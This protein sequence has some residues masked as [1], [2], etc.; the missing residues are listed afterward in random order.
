MWS[1]NL[2][3]RSVILSLASSQFAS[4]DHRFNCLGGDKIDGRDIVQFVRPKIESQKCSLCS[5]QRIV[6][7]LGTLAGGSIPS[8]SLSLS[9]SLSLRSPC[10]TPADPATSHRTPAPRGCHRR[11]HLRATCAPIH[12]RPCAFGRGG[13]IATPLWLPGEPEE[14]GLD[15]ACEPAT[16]HRRHR[17]HAAIGTRRV[18]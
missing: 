18:H 6:G 3:E 15:C 14:G 1:G 9:P 7:V 2:E 4:F 10:L 17:I 16:L 5:R 12:R 8:L 11:R 13:A